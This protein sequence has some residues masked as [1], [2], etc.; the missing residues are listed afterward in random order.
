[1]KPHI[2]P[3]RFDHHETARLGYRTKRVNDRD[4]PAYLVRVV[5]LNAEG[6]TTHEQIWSAIWR[7]SQVKFGAARGN[8]N[9]ACSNGP[10]DYS[11][12]L[13]Q[14]P[15]GLQPLHLQ[16]PEQRR[17]RHRGARGTRCANGD[18]GPLRVPAAHDVGR[19]A[20]T[21]RAPRPTAD[22]CGTRA[23]RS[24]HCF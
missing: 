17:Q 24:A 16:Q 15:W 3:L 10:G 14:H 7:T 6:R 1:M 4:V 5:R 13:Q 20:H 12:C 8:S 2:R 18:E 19:N 22:C 11:P 9:P 23:M 21:S